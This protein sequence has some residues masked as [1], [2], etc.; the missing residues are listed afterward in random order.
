MG[1]RLEYIPLR[2][3][4]FNLIPLHYMLFP[5]H[6]HCINLLVLTSRCGEVSSMTYSIVLN[7]HDFAVRPFPDYLEQ[8]EVIERYFW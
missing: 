7:Q 5:K 8:S 6:L 1:D 3:G 2:L 4:V